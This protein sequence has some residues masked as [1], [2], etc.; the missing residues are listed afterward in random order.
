MGT[1]GR[2]IISMDIDK[3]LEMLNKA[4]AD[5]WLAYYQYWLGAKVA[6]GPMKDAVIAELAQHAGDELRHADMVAMRIIQI[7]GI[8][9]TTPKKWFELSHCGYAA[10]EDPQV[11]ALLKQN[12]K[13]EQC[14]I[15]VYKSILDATAQKD[16]VTYNMVL[17]ILQDEVQHEEDLQSLQEDL[18]GII[19]HTRK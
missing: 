12:I 2:S 3:L 4:F 14:A 19:K 16:P 13:G 1:K 7:G 6:K 9:V 8:P 17:Q 10:P 18:T 11:E 15:G 5:E